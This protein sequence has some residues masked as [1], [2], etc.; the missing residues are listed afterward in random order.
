MIL[1]NISLQVPIMDRRSHYFSGRFGHSGHQ[2][3]VL[4]YT[5]GYACSICAVTAPTYPV[6]CINGQLFSA[7]GP[8]RL[9]FQA[10]YP[11]APTIP[12]QRPNPPPITTTHGG[13]T[14]K[15][16]APIFSPFF[17]F[18]QA[19]K[20]TIFVKKIWIFF[21]TLKLPLPTWHTN[22]F[23]DQICGYKVTKEDDFYFVRRAER[24]LE[25]TL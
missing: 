14:P 2:S 9:Q 16:R 25:Y 11:L 19:R 3:E 17:T 15:G 13:L 20:V 1:M 10:N 4:E 23:T 8:V 22:F 7:H 21:S 24:A 18:G 12:H 5:L 6:R